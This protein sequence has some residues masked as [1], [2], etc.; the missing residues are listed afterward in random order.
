MSQ[1][2]VKIMDN[3]D[4]NKIKSW[5]DILLEP[6]FQDKEILVDQIRNSKMHLKEAYTDACFWKFKVDKGLALFPHN[7]YVPIK[8]RI[9][10]ANGTPIDF[11]LFV[12]DGV[13]DEFGISDYDFDYLA[14]EHFD[15]SNRIYMI[16]ANIT[17]CNNNELIEEESI[18]GYRVLVFHSLI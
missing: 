18:P 4:E 16:S 6:N 3:I 13:V 7:N 9:Q 17:I 8:M 1:I 15:F 11:L 2:G 14:P 5:I 12:K 10:R